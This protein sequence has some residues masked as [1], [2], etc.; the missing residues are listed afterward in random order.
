MSCKIETAFA[1]REMKIME[2][3]LQKLGYSFSKMNNSLTIKKRFNNIIISHT[4]VSCDSDNTIEVEKI[5][6]EYSKNV[7]V[8]E[9]ENEGVIYEIEETKNEIVILA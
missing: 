6:S 7:Y 5:K 3:T 1:V 9:F 8:S 2:D 4:K